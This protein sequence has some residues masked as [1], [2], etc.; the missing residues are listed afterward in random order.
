MGS[1]RHLQ[2]GAVVQG[3]DNVLC[4]LVQ[5]CGVRTREFRTYLW[6]THGSLPAQ[7]IAVS[8]ANGW[9]VQLTSADRC[10]AG[11]SRVRL[12]ARRPDPLTTV[13]GAHVCLGVD[14]A[15]RHRLDF[16]MFPAR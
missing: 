4:V 6:Q 15:D 5:H 14:P 3:H 7:R 9:I 2:H 10:L 11:A 1:W 13:A 16:V 12:L 8:G